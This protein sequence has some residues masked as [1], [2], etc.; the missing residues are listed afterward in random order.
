M[1]FM[2]RELG[3]RYMKAIP[4]IWA[5]IYKNMRNW[6]T[7]VSFFLLFLV[8]ILRGL[9]LKSSPILCTIKQRLV[10]EKI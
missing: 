2:T 3:I 10:R 8:N 5:Q 4:R 7:K 9:K 1:S 6:G